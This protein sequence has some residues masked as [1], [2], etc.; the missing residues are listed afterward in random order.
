[1]NIYI[2]IY[3]HT[4]KVSLQHVYYIRNGCCSR[5]CCILSVFN[6]HMRNIPEICVLSVCVCVC[7]CV[8][9]CVLVSIYTD[10]C[11]YLYRY[12]SV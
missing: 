11:M 1:M 3:I 12:M 2:Y 4:Y 8:R 7:V 10:T 5:G 6:A 9:V